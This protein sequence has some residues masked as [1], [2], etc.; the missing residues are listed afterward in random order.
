MPRFVKRY[1]VNMIICVEPDAPF[2]EIDNGDNEDVILELIKDIIYDL[3]D[4][5]VEEIEVEHM[6]WE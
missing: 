4:V 2:L 5:K 3:D 1:G 6:E